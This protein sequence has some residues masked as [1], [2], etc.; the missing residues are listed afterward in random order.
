M[1]EINRENCPIC[2]STGYRIIKLDDVSI[3]RCI[4]CNHAYSNIKTIENPET[5]DAKYYLETH[6]RWLKTL[7]KYF[8]KK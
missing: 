3:N 2:A 8:L 5:Y 7:I 4:G 6:K 1:K